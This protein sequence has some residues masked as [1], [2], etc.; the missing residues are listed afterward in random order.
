MS[1]I[2]RIWAVVS[3]TTTLSISRSRPPRLATARCRCG[4]ASIAGYACY[5]EHGTTYHQPRGVGR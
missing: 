1:V 2:D 5:C 3:P 4:L